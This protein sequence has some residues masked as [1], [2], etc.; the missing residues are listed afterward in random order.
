MESMDTSLLDPATEQALALLKRLD[1]PPSTPSDTVVV[2]MA[3]SRQCAVSLQQMLRIAPSAVR[4]IPADVLVPALLRYL[5]HRIRER[6]YARK[7][8]EAFGENP[9]PKGRRKKAEMWNLDA[10]QAVDVEI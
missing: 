10:P 2:K 1:I 3:M 4:R 8:Y 7:R 9:Q 6:M 5:R